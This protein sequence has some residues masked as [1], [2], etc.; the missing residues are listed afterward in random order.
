MFQDP[1][2]LDQCK[3]LVYRLSKARSPWICAHG[4]PSMVPLGLIGQGKGDMER[5]IDW[6]KFDLA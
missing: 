3:R 6:T 2:D 5:K 1:L 4:R